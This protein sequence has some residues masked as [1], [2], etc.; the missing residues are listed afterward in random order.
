MLSLWLNCKVYGVPN[1]LGQD[2][3]CNI[4]KLWSKIYF[5]LLIIIAYCNFLCHRNCQCYLLFLFICLV[6]IIKHRLHLL[7]A[8]VLLQVTPGKCIKWYCIKRSQSTDRS[9]YTQQGNVSNKNVSSE[10]NQPT[11]LHSRE[12]YQIKMY[13][14]KSINRQRYTAGKCI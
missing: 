1:L 6:L 12:M 7:I 4:W 10:V 3:L 2:N 13:Q 11:E 14:V 5:I 9:I 8:Q